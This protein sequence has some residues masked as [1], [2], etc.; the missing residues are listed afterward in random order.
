MHTAGVFLW[1]PPQ[2]AHSTEFFFRVNEQQQSFTYEKASYPKTVFVISCRCIS[3]FRKVW[4]NFSV[5]NPNTFAIEP[6]STYI[7]WMHCQGIWL[8]NL[9]SHP[10]SFRTNPTCC[11]CILMYYPEALA[12]LIS[13]VKEFTLSLRVFELASNIG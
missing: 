6:C 10:W 1:F 9:K 5:R 8:Y 4:I 11:P 13:T 2:R 7:G 12:A 3:L